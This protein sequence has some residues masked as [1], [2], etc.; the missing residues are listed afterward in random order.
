[1]LSTQDKA[2]IFKHYM[3]QYFVKPEPYLYK[4]FQTEF[5]EDYNVL[6]CYGDRYTLLQCGVAF[7]DYKENY[8]QHTQIY[9]YDLLN[10]FL[11]K[12][13]TQYSQVFYEYPACPLVIYHPLGTTSN[14]RLMSLITHVYSYRNLKDQKTLILSECSILS[15]IMDRVT[16]ILDLSTISQIADEGFDE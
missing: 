16:P 11:D 6:Y 8:K 13:D 1:M 10:T 3:Q 12:S 15:T 5:K 7:L 9:S 14:Q 4:A 2:K